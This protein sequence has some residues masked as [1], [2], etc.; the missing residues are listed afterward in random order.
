[1]GKTSK[2]LNQI[3]TKLYVKALICLIYKCGNA[4][5]NIISMTIGFFFNIRGYNKILI[6]SDFLHGIFVN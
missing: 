6:V 2:P 3:K 4:A 5:N 1:M